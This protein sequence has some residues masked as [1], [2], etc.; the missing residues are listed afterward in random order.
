MK[1]EITE[2][3]Q[4][5]QIQSEDAS[6]LFELIDSEREYLGQ[7][8]PFVPL[9]KVVSDTEAYVLSLVNA[10]LTN[11]EY[12][13]TIWES[14]KIIG[15]IGFI[16]SDTHNK[17]TEIGYWMSQY[18]QGKGIMTKCV[19]ALCH[20]AFEE[21]DMNRIQIKCAIGNTPSSNI[22]KRLGFYFEGIE[23]DGEIYAQNT[24]RDLEVYSLLKNDFYTI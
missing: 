5:K 4:L 16:R 1:I 3:I 10:P 12:V 8:L 21:L 14:E 18:A 20:F 9:T 15:L 6:A 13:F 11:F 2:N 22:P 19:K 17:K 24:F 7:W 23:R